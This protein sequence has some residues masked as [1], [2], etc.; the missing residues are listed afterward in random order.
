[1]QKCRR[2]LTAPRSVWTIEKSPV[3]R[4]DGKSH[5]RAHVVRP[6]L[7]AECAEFTEEKPKTTWWLSFRLETCE[8]QSREARDGRRMLAAL[9]AKSLWAARNANVGCLGDLRVLRVTI[10]FFE[11]NLGRG[12]RM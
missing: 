4:P 3:V 10:V 2:R 6:I 1:M 11:N 9:R 8:F 5:I 7:H 12:R